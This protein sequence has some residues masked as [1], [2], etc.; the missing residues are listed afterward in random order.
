M[1][2]RNIFDAIVRATG[3][4]PS[5]RT[6]PENWLIGVPGIV[7]V[8]VDPDHQH[9]IQVIIPSINE[10]EVYDE[11]ARRIV[12]GFTGTPGYGDFGVP[13]LGSEVML[14]GEYGQKH[15]LFYAP[16]YNEKN[17]APTDFSTSTLYGVRVPGDY[18]QIVN[19]NA[20]LKAGLIN[21]ESRSDVQ[22][23]APGGIFLNGRPIAQ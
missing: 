4:K 19:F 21:F 22:I 10:N 9:R 1:P 6:N 15:H 2:G 11:W 14:I 13:S 12:G 5:L 3:N 7:A 18:S 20:R 17:V 23:I 16:V 8:N